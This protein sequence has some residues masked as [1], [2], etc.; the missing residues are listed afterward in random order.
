M[1]RY[2]TVAI[3]VVAALSV[4]NENVRGRL[5]AQSRLGGQTPAADDWPMHNRDVYSTRF[6][7]LTQISATNAGSLTVKWSY[8]ADPSIGAE[9]PLVVDGVMYLNM[10]SSFV[11]LDAATGDVKWKSELQPKAAGGRRG[12]TFGGGKV[13]GYSTDTVYA[14]DAKTGKA[15]DSFGDGGALRIINRA[16]EFKYPGKYPADALPRNLG[17]GLSSPPKYFDNTLFIGT[18]DSDN[19]ISGGLVVAANATTGAIKWVFNTVPQSPKDDGWE[20]AKDTWASSYRPGGGLW[21]EPALDP[22]LGM[23][24]VGTANPSPDYDGSARH[25][26]NLFT[27]ST[28]AL[29][30][31]TGKLVWHFQ[32]VHHDLWDRDSI[33]GP[34]LFDVTIDGRDVKAIGNGGKSCY[35]FFWDRRTGTPLNPVVEMPVPMST[36]VPGEQPWPTQPIPFTSRGVPQQPFCATYPT[37]TDPDLVARVRPAFHPWQ[38]KEFII[39][40]PGLMGGGN[41]GSPSFS[42]RTGLFYITGKNDA[43]SIK[44]NK[45]GDLL[46]AGAGDQGHFALINAEG[47]T[48]MTPTTTV[49]AYNPVTGAVAW[50]STIPAATNAGNLVTAGGVVFQGGGAG[51]FYGFDASTGR[52]VFKYSAGKV[53]MRASPMTY[54]ARGKQY[55]AVVAGSSVLA[56][57]LP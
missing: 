50:Q 39:T 46:K 37:V 17:W 15:V 27:D 21:T 29:N 55:V 9:T 20:I 47:K 38:M 11:A 31:A 52:E 49:T 40:S 13:Y 44:L 16:L 5:H 51:D 7:P 6:S 25:G 53:G 1:S 24:Y 41:Y 12:P 3:C 36:D 28:I 22:E 35:A 43:W 56:L 19:L 10:G 26:S 2:V 14:V 42:P 23:L 18:S 45:V 8:Q 54:A 32:T 30:A 57:G 33:T 48:G 4:R 34:V